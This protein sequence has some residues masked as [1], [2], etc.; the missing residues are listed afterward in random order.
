M[1]WRCWLQVGGA[2]AT[3]QT[4]VRGLSNG[5]DR[6]RQAPAGSRGLE[7]EVGCRPAVL[8]PRLQRAPSTAAEAV[9]SGPGGRRRRRQAEQRPA[10]RR[11]HHRAD[12]L[13]GARAA[14]RRSASPEC[15]RPRERAADALH[16]PREVEPAWCSRAAVLDADIAPGRQHGRACRRQAGRA[17]LRNVAAVGVQLPVPRAS[18]TRSSNGVI[19]D[20][21]LS[22]RAIRAQRGRTGGL[23]TTPLQ[24]LWLAGRLAVGLAV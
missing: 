1:W 22:A 7:A 19:A 2:G 15:A 3:S 11:G 9:Q 14:P 17:G 24:A 10:D 20:E 21:E 8:A 18:S 6:G 16:E 23:S 13:P 12:H 5:R 4:A